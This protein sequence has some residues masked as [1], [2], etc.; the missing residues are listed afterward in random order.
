MLTI[1]FIEN[2]FSNIVKFIPAHISKC[3]ECVILFWRRDS[4]EVS[5]EFSNARVFYLESLNFP[6]QNFPILFC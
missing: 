1:R 4:E 3:L 6:F 2:V 5:V